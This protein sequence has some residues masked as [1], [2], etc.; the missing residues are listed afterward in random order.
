[1][2]LNKVMDNLQQWKYRLRL[3]IEKNSRYM[4]L[5]SFSRYLAEFDHQRYDDVDIPG[6]YLTVHFKKKLK[7]FNS[8]SC[9]TL[10]LIL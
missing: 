1:M 6:Q 10:V 9:E 2:T 4:Q 8:S 7:H 5:E 3:L